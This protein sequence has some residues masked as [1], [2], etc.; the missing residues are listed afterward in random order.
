MIFK[1]HVVQ[2]Y[3][4]NGAEVVATIRKKGRYKL[5]QKVVLKVGDKV[6]KGEVVAIAPLTSAPFYVEYSGFESVEE[7]LYEAER[8]H[9][10]LNPYGYEIVVVKVN[11]SGA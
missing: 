2:D 9:K 5:G 11:R 6:L 10:G 8:L 4:L 1:S 7:W 3:I